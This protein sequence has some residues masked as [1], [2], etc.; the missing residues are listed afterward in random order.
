MTAGSAPDMG[1]PPPDGGGGAAAPWPAWGR[2]LAIGATGGL[3]AFWVALPLAWM[4]GA[5][6]ACTAASVA[7]VRLPVLRVAIPP[8]LRQAMIAV[9]GTMLGAGFTPDVLAGMIAWW[10]T[11]L[12]LVIHVVISTA[13]AVAY[14]QRIGRLGRTTGYF[15][16]MPGGLGEMILLVEIYGGNAR[17]LALMHGVRVLLLVMTLPWILQAIDGPIER[18]A[19]IGAAPIGGGGG[20]PSLLDLALPDLALPDLALLGLSAVMGALIALRLRLPAATLVGPLLLSALL[21]LTGLTDA[22]VPPLLVAV[23]QVVIGAAI[24]C[25]F[26]GAEWPLLRRAVGLSLGLIGLLLVLCI[27]G[28]WLLHLATGVPL[29]S[30]ILAFAPGGL[31]EMTLIALAMQIDPAFIATHHIIR[32]V[33]LVLFA[34]IVYRLLYGTAPP[35]PE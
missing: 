7:S 16:G 13:L 18:V 20:G 27:A 10:Q 8:V 5:M 23:A 25:R 14:C 31:A 17:V 2:A 28:G 29:A 6:L 9:L 3:L 24:G 4:V 1:T 21:H 26:A 19:T 30:C 35:A 22:A 11:V 15:S 12:G 34:P 33:M 32:I